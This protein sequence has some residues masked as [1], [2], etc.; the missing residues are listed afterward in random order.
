VKDL[1]I[2]EADCPVLYRN[3]L[4]DHACTC[5]APTTAQLM[6]LVDAAEA[7]IAVAVKELEIDTDEWYEWPEFGNLDL[8]LRPFREEKK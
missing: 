4:L 6:E 7:S 8:A 5:H 3:G 2:H 1:V